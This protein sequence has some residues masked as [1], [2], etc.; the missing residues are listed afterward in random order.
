[1][2]SLPSEMDSPVDQEPLLILS[3]AV[4]AGHALVETRHGLISTADL[5]LVESGFLALAGSGR[6]LDGGLVRV[7][8]GL[9]T[10]EDVLALLFLKVSARVHGLLDGVLVGACPTLQSVPPGLWGSRDGQ[11]IATLGAEEQHY[12]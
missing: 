8:P 3:P 10:A 7:R 4:S 2:L 12:D 6:A 11:D 5:D 1:M 9:G